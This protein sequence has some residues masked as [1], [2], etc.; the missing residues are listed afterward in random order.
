ML[1]EFQISSSVWYLLLLNKV[2]NYISILTKTIPI[3]ERKKQKISEI[4]V[5][6]TC[7]VYGAT[8][9]FQLQRSFLNYVRFLIGQIFMRFLGFPLFAPQSDRYFDIY[10]LKFIA[11]IS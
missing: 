11:L 10:I 4:M 1:L 6:L 7:V 5:H 8:H 9:F 3:L 2:I